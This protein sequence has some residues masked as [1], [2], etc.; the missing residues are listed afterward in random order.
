MKVLKASLG[1]IEERTGVVAFVAPL[2]FHH[3]PRN[4]KWWYVFGSATLM[5]FTIQLVTG[6]C[7]ATVYAP[8]AAQAWESL[9][10]IDNHVPMGWML[11]ALHGWSSNAMVVMMAIHMLQVFLH[12]SYKYP[13]ELNWITGVFLLLTTLAL[14]F[15]GQVMR[16]DQDAYWG[17][18]IGAAIADRIPL[19]GDE[20][21]AL[22]LGGPIIG[23]ATL[24]RFFAL[25][26]FVLPGAAIALVGLHMVLIIKNG[27]SEMPKPGAVVVPSMYRKEFE[28]R[29]HKDGVPFVPDAAQRDM[30]FC[31]VCLI[32]LVALAAFYGP[33][34]PGGMP[35][36]TIIDTNP[37]PDYPF[38]WL[39]GAVSLLP[40][41]S[42][43]AIM[44]IAPAVG[45]LILVA[46]PFMS[47]S[48]E[49]APSKRPAM[50]L[51]ALVTVMAIAA[52]T[53]EG[54]TSS[55]SPV[56]NGWSSLPTP[57]KFVRGRTPLEMQGAVVFQ[58][59]Q[60]RNCHSL[61]GLGGKRGPELDDVATRL[62]YDQLVRQVQQ[63]GGNMPAY[64]KNLDSAQTAAVVA[65][66][67][68]LHPANEP[69]SRIP[70]AQLS[71]P[72]DNA[73]AR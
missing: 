51:I 49:R 3:V 8:S 47:N 63:G 10:Y 17:L 26:V 48:G 73:T 55:W 35:D 7:L 14:A 40:P 72:T 12:A 15:T 18:G 24:N 28:E 19:V 60:C 23:G 69:D 29:M 4:A 61:D 20:V 71:V 9:N 22:L 33:F 1:W 62:S 38:M 31:G 6:V 34:G 52:L 56:M 36:P 65:F 37:R 45:V 30:V 53:W 16:W 44:L 58:F 68:T 42:E 57:V 70:G 2:L 13:R 27:I 25:H 39:F 21:R 43:T 50:V 32:G 41:S 46:L 54:T 11:R 5:F 66:L 59:A 67:A 64:G